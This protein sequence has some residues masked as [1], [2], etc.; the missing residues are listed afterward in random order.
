MPAKQD[1]GKGKA[2]DS[3]PEMP[4]PAILDAL[5]GNLRYV[6][7]W[8]EGLY[9]RLIA[10]FTDDAQMWQ[11]FSDHTALLVCIFLFNIICLISNLP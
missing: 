10:R 11:E 4:S 5:E 9:N 1:K 8:V 2:V 6:H 3:E 7:H